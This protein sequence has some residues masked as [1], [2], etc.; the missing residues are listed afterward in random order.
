[1]QAVCLPQKNRSSFWAFCSSRLTFFWSRNSGWSCSEQTQSSHPAS[2]NSWKWVYSLNWARWFKKRPPTR[3]S[4]LLWSIT[5]PPRKNRNKHL[6]GFWFLPSNMKTL[7]V[8]GIYQIEAPRSEVLI[9]Q[10]RNSVWS[11]CWK[12]ER[13]HGWWSPCKSRRWNRLSISF[14]TSSDKFPCTISH[15]VSACSTLIPRVK[16]SLI[17]SRWRI[18]YCTWTVKNVSR[19]TKQIPCFRSQT[20][21]R[22]SASHKDLEIFPLQADW[23]VLDNSLESFMRFTLS[24]N[25]CICEVSSWN[26]CVTFSQFIAWRIRQIAIPE[27]IFNSSTSWIFRMR[28]SRSAFSRW[29][30]SSWSLACSLRDSS[31]P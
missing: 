26:S 18:D 16:H 28:V 13:I 25:S 3:P 15:W 30:N 20:I 10:P 4:P 24:C 21:G 5:L 8:W 14:F 29:A 7:R 9:D 2:R 6:L 19:C 23:D 11:F 12:K 31:Y 1:M 27:L 17:R 22:G